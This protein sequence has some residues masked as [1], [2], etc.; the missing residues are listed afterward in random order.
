M[1]SVETSVKTRR[2]AIAL[3]LLLGAAMVTSTL[4]QGALGVLSRFIL[5]EFGITRSQFGLVFSVYSVVGGLSALYIGTLA[6]KNTRMVMLGLF[7]LAGA[8]IAGA[9]IAPTYVLLV[10][11]VLVGGFALGAG[12]PVTNRVIAERVSVARR[13]LV[14]GIKQAGPPLGLFIAG[15]ALPIIA[16]SVG[17]RWA[18]ST[19]VIV[20]AVGLAGTFALMPRGSGV[21]SPPTRVSDLDHRVRFIVYSLTVIGA[22]VSVANSAAIAFLPLFAQE[23][24]SMTPTLAGAVAAIMGL[25]GV[26]GRILW[27]GYAPRFKK[28]SSALLVMSIFSALSFAAIAS[29]T[30]L[31]SFWLWIGAIGGGASVLAWHAIAYL[32]IVNR[33]E[34]AAVGRASG[35]MHM[36]STFGFAAGAPLAGLL[37]DVSNSYVLMWSLLAVTMALVTGGTAQFRLTAAKR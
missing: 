31:G 16:V 20:P 23:D 22:A 24:L 37:L 4:L 26:V 34:M 8:S 1:S 18:L 5:D 35:I 17:W 11:A 30:A 28:P 3:V 12:N 32:V 33:V 27:G 15:I 6:D 21:E 2:R 10:V 9:A 36:G 13:G 25:A 19:A 14:I 7:L 29:S